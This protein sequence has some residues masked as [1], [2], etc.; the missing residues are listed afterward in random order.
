[1]R[2]IFSLTLSCF[3]SLITGC[4]EETSQS[5]ETNPATTNHM[6]EDFDHDHHHVHGDGQDHEHGHSDGFH[7]SHSHKHSHSHRHGKPVY[8][9]RVVSIGHSHH[10]DGATHYHAEVMPATDGKIIF[11]LLTETDEGKLKDFSIDIEK[12]KG[13]ANRRVAKSGESRP[14]QFTREE[15]DQATRF[16]ASVPESLTDVEELM[17]MIPRIKL[18]GE[19]LNFSFRVIQEVS[20]TEDKEPGEQQ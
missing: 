19:R 3:M 4:G 5:Q 16:V 9:G 20:K 2:C 1:M 7:G 12:L 15:F 11:Y 13:Y 10:K 14:L 8:G 18:G 17:V 6:H